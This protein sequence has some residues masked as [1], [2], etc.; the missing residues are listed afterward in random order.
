MSASDAL[1]IGAGPAGSIAALTLARAGARVRLID[2]ASF[3]RDKLCGDTLESGI[4][5][6]PRP[7]RDR[8]RRAS[9]R[10]ADY[11]HDRDRS[12]RAGLG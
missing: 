7:A 9:L 2:R 6:D 5:V 10:L 3:P 1:V 8:R 12:G 11:R 4:A